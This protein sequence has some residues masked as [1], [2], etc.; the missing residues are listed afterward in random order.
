MQL[1]R[2]LIEC[3][4][5]CARMNA[6]HSMLVNC[7]PWSE[8]ISTAVLRLPPPYRHVQGLQNHVGRLSALHR[9]A[10]DTAREKIQ[11]DSQVGEALMGCGY[12]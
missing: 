11:H 9:P 2:R 4:R 7:E 12:R 10:D 3:S 6:A 1:P 8:W 5:L